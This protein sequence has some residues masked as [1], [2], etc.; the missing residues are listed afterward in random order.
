V[1]EPDH[2]DTVRPMD[3]GDNPT[4]P[5]AFSQ[6]DTLEP[7]QRT[8]Q[9][10]AGRYR[11]TRL[12]GRGGMGEVYLAEHI[13]L[14]SLVAIKYMRPSL[15][16]NPQ[17]SSRFMR[18]AQAL[19]LL[20]HPH[21]VAVHDFGASSNDFYLVM[22]FLDGSAALLLAR[23]PPPAP[24]PGPRRDPLRSG[25][26]RPGVCPREGHRPPGHQARQ[27][28]PLHPRRQAVAQARRLRPRP[29]RR[30]G[31]PGRQAHLHRN[32]RRDAALHEPRAVPLPL[33]RAL[34]GSLLD[35]LRPHG[36]APGLPSLLLR[37]PRRDPGAA[38]V[39]PGAAPRPPRGAPPGPGAP[40]EAPHGPPQQV[41][42]QAPGLRRRGPP[43]PAGGPPHRRG[44]ALRRPPG[45][46]RGPR[47]PH[48]SLGPGPRFR[49][50]PVRRP[51]PP[52]RYP[53]PE[54]GSAGWA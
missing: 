29:H 21:I 24:A 15:A 53:P 28:L 12:I 37:L 26:R 39:P 31:R 22:E 34:R 38:H 9:V 54:G 33:R 5:A 44:P 51:P 25:P 10:I 16:A 52:P 46:P 11:L 36:D 48:P 13:M 30:G 3:S 42:Q 4:L 49:R 43:A 35:G 19:S 2:G 6:E 50:P 18:E 27:P 17:N 7:E 32:D 1:R 40:G 41:R 14:R 45:R 8:G 20:R 23:E 47:R